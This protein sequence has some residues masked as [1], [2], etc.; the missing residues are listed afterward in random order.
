MVVHDLD[1]V[2]VALS[3]AKRD[4]PLPVDPAAELS[5]AITSESLQVIARQPAEV[6]QAAGTPKDLEPLLRLARKPSNRRT[7]LPS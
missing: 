3:P 1:V 7:R 6:V 4:A 2:S 5:R